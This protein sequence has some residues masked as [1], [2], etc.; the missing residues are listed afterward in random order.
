MARAVFR[1]ISKN[2]THGQHRA[3]DEELLQ[4]TLDYMKD[5]FQS[6]IATLK[7]EDRESGDD[8]EVMYPR[9]MKA[10]K[11]KADKFKQDSRGYRQIC[12]MP[13]FSL[14]L[15]MVSRVRSHYI[16]ADWF[17]ITRLNAMVDIYGGV[18]ASYSY[19]ITH[20]THP[21]S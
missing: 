1:L 20:L 5:G 6:D 21:S 18:R 3:T 17:K 2:A 9:F 14:A 19:S 4:E 10:V 12:L 11:K 8:Y 7:E 15:V 13:T 16:H